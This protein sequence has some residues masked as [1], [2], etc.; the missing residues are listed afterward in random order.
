MGE[1]DEYEDGELSS[2]EASNIEDE[3]YYEEQ[4]Q[5]DEMEEENE[6]R[7]IEE[8]DG[9]EILIVDEFSQLLKDPKALLHKASDVLRR[10]FG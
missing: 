1:R 2:D 3:E 9:D 10:K 5:V 4:S 8:E 7:S 6:E